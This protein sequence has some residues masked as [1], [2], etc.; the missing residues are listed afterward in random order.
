LMIQHNPIARNLISPCR[1]YRSSADGLKKGPIP[2]PI[3]MGKKAGYC[4]EN[5]TY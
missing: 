1:Q 4:N 5:R 2:V 3:G